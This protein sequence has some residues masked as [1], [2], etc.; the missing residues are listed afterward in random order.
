MGSLLYRPDWPAAR[1]RLTRWWNGSDI[2]RAAMM[3]YAPRPE[4]WEAIPKMEP[5]AGWTGRY[6]TSSVAYR[7]YLAR[8]AGISTY[9]L[10]EAVP[11]KASAGDAGPNC[12]AL[13]LGCT[14]VEAPDTVW[15]NPCIAEPEQARFAYDPHNFYWQFSLQA[16]R[17]TA[18]HAQGRFLQQF[19]DLIEGLDTLAA[20]RGS[21]QLLHDLIDRPDWVHAALRRITDLYFRYYDVLYDLLRDEVGGSVFWAWAPGRIAKFQCDMSAMISPT[22]FRDFMGPVLSEMCERVSYSMYHWDGPDALRHHDCLLSIER[23]NVI[24]W[25]PGAGI[26]P[27]WHKRWWPYYHKTLDAGK[28]LYIH[29]GGQNAEETEEQLLALKREFGAASKGMLLELGAPSVAVAE[30]WFKM[31]EI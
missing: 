16:F 4:P 26:E 7:V 27:T 10:G 29:I 30:K 9:Y 25:T 5:P 3:I 24:Q 15:F 17:E 6:S 23:L 18:Q 8:R 21:E 22:M 14:G 12:L 2:G 28:K 1:E 31:M 11:N 13:Y 19:P 20:M